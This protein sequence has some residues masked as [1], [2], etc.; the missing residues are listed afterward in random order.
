MKRSAGGSPGPAGFEVRAAT[1]A[2]GP[3][4][5]AINAQGVPGVGAL[6]P[7][8]VET[9]LRLAD[10]FRVAERPAALAAYLI[11]LHSGAAYDGEEFL[12]FRSRFPEFVYV[13]QV[14]VAQEARG[15]GAASA[16]YDDLEEFA[17]GRGIHRLALEVNLR[18]ENR[19]SIA[20]HD[21]LG[22]SEVGRLETADGRLVSLRLKEIRLGE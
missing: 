14:A 15:Q 10:W 3:G 9:F 13:D 21:R 2:D 11:A 16:L 22:F 12:W 6:G 1:R 7:S 17:A 4:I 8:D 20:F 18:P 5:L 19:P